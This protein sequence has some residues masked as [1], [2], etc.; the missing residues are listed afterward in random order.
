MRAAVYLRQSQDRSGEG[1]G[2]DRQ[3]DDVRRLI[4]SRGWT[5]AAEFVDNDVSATSRKPRPQFSAMMTRV[6]AGEFDVIVARHM[7]RLLRRLAELEAVL[8]RC[9]LASVAIV[10]AAD[11]VDTSSDGGRLVARILS[12][13]AQGEVERKGARQRSAAVQAAKQGRWIGGRR[14]FGYESDGVTIREGEA[15]L[16][17][18]GYA[19]VLNGESLA[20]IARRWQATGLVPTQEAAG[21]HRGNVKDVLTNPRS[22]GL[23]RYRSAEDRASIRQ[24]P[25]LG[26]TGTAEW[27]PIVDEATWRAAVRILCDPARRRAPVGPKGLLTGV[28]VCGVCGETVHRGGATNR[29]PMYRCRSGRHVSRQ[30]EPVDAYVEAV[31][32]EV[33]KRPD[34]AL[35][36]SDDLPDASELMA[37]ADTLRR[38]RDDIAVDYAD[39]VM[40]REQ[41]RAMNE[42][43]LGRLADVEAKIAAAGSAS[44]LAIVAAEDVDAAWS[45][46]SVARRRAIIDALCTPVL[47][48]SV[49]GSRSFNPDTVTFRWRRDDC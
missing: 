44:P 41:F 15:A 6:D 23:R 19:D 48:L 2:I 18:Q 21:W 24:N 27:P 29:K 7:D 36:W 38:R 4:A 47:H 25:E 11:G 40:T 33:L 28:A 43:V 45:D 42:R 16:I 39:G 31:V 26:I 37:E 3:R 20:E 46:L 12:S 9:Q 8:E 1:L 30:S 17:R 13:V 49:R 22:A 32:L 5:M 10:T 14:A 34:A 35:L